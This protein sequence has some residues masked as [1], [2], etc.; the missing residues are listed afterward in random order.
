MMAWWRRRFTLPVSAQLL[1]VGP[2]WLGSVAALTVEEMPTAE[3]LHADTDCADDMCSQVLC[4]V[5][6]ATGQAVARIQLC[7]RDRIDAV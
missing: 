3:S 5:L 6:C 7:K 4:W 2:G 1:G